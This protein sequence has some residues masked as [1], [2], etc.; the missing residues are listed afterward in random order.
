M[1]P[2]KEVKDD[3]RVLRITVIDDDASV[4]R[5]ISRLARSYGFSCTAFESGESALMS[6]DLGESDCL[7]VDIQLTGIDGFETRDRLEARGVRLP[8]IFITAHPEINSPEWQSRLRG[9][10]FLTKPFEEG[11]LFGIID[12]ILGA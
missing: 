5:G 9:Y 2:T 12:R 3:G 4:R 6:P 11:E 7:I 10:P 8:L 1:S